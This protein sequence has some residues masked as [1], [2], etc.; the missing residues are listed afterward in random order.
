MGAASRR[1]W[2]ERGWKAQ[3]ARGGPSG[4]PGGHLGMRPGICMKGRGGVDR[5]VGLPG[6]YVV[7]LGGGAG[8]GRHPG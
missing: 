5:G 4:G 7:G 6:S 1:F 3:C 2:V 8:R